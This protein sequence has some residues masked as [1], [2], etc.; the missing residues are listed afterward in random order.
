VKIVFYE[1]GNINVIVGA[2]ELTGNL[3]IEQIKNEG[4]KQSKELGRLLR[5][6]I[7]FLLDMNGRLETGLAMD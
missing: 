5:R 6:E 3:T 7:G 1:K 4:E 2:S